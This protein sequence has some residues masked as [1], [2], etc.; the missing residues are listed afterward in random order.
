M[1][2]TCVAPNILSKSSTRSSMLD[3]I[4]SLFPL[5]ILYTVCWK[6][7]FLLL[8]LTSV[9]SCVLFEYLWQSYVV[10]GNNTTTDLSSLLT[11]V[12]LALCLS[13]TVPLWTV[14]I[15]S[16][17]SIVVGKMFFGGL[18]KNIF[19]PAL[20]GVLFIYLSFPIKVSL[21]SPDRYNE[22]FIACIFVGFIYL[23]FKNIITLYIPL[24]Y[25]IASSLMMYTYHIDFLSVF[26]GGLLFGAIFLATDYT[27]SP[28]T[29]HGKIIFAICCGILTPIIQAYSGIMEG[30]M[31]SILFMNMFVPIIDK[32]TT[33]RVFGVDK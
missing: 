11:G 24:A 7:D 21:F 22:V 10:K 28:M 27:T 9:A 12:I 8:L 2:F 31:F 23:L 17:F 13:S 30:V 20:L 1:L 26:S 16:F 6:I 32:Y 3:V 33:P 19:N 18:G 14:V 4:L 15:A 25:I 5:V 29:K